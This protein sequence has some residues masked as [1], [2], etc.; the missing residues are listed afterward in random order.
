M[1]EDSIK[2][3]K[4]GEIIKGSNPERENDKEL[5]G[6]LK[7]M[8]GSFGE[9]WNHN[10]PLLI[11]RTTLSRIMYYAEIYQKIINIP[12]VICEFGVQWG[13]TMALL[14]NFRGMYEPFN[15]TRTIYGFDTFEGFPTIDEKDGDRVKVGDYHSVNNYEDV[16]EKVLSLQ[17]S[18]SPIN[19]LKKF[20][21]IKGD[22]SVTI[23][24][25]LDKNPHA[26]IAL[27]IFDMDLYKPTKD[28]LEMIL[29]RLTKGSVLVFDELNAPD[30]PG[31]T[32]AVQEV[33]GLNNISLRKFPHQ[34]YASWAV[35]GE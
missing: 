28:V 29:P 35:F 1:K 4:N 31:E 8:V 3:T 23:K 24:G 12:G 17:E 10:L 34:S 26:I 20:E 32:I 15:Y 27:A 2:K 16:L 33:L 6:V 30:F 7:D 11:R 5:L 18:F 9:S 14:Q 21:L 25:W 22:A 13:A 19:H